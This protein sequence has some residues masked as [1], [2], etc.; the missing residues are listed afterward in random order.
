LLA[1]F[2][3]DMPSPKS[4]LITGAGEESQEHSFLMPFGTALFDAA[5]WYN[6]ARQR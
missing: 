6:P 1:S 3:P 2:N 5:A 4:S